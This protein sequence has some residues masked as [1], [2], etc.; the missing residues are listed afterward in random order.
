MIIC[1]LHVINISF[2]LLRFQL[3]AKYHL[4]S[5]R[6]QKKNRKKVMLLG[7]KCQDIYYTFV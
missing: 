7:Y 5:Y 6:S 2:W 1:F 4:F 3:Q